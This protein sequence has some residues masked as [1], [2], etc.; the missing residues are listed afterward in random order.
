MPLWLVLRDRV[1]T[2]QQLGSEVK[3]RQT[4][5]ILITIKNIFTFYVANY[6]MD[7]CCGLCGQ[8]LAWWTYFRTIAG[9]VD[10]FQR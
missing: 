6:R 4:I 9:L 2:K 10:L 5:N 1:Q 8:L 7:L 3:A